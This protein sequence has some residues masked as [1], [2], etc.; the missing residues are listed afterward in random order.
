MRQVRPGPA[1]GLALDV[2]ALLLAAAGVGVA[3]V[4][5]TAGGPAAILPLL[6]LGVFLTAAAVCEAGACIVRALARR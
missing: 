3:V 5:W 4:T 6:G 2:L 1:P